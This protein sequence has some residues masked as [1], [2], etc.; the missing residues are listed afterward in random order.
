MN[1]DAIG[2]IGEIIGALAVFIT[3]AYLALQIRQNTRAVHSSALDS[4]VNT[5]SIARQSIYENDE[6]AKVYLKGLSLPSSLND[7]ERVK[8]RLLVHNLM[9]AQSNIFA[10]TQF[11]D[12]PISEWNAQKTI[13]KRVLSSPGGQWFW[14][15]FGCEFDE[16]FRKE[17]ERVM[18]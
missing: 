15:E 12:L 4:T 14:E 2:A 11:S 6:V 16:E 13:I 5:I 3:L 18:Q 7:V 17:V 10:Q 1:W 8:F 9:H